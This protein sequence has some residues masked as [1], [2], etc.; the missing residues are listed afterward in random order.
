MNKRVYGRAQRLIEQ[1]I[2]RSNGLLAIQLDVLVEILAPDETE[3]QP[4][5]DFIEQTGKMSSHHAQDLVDGRSDARRERLDFFEVET[6]FDKIQED[7]L[8][9][10]IDGFPELT[11]LYKSFHF[12]AVV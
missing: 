2:G 3:A 7:L 8:L 12:L 4:R 6:L 9:L 10:V 1:V 11:Q 5:N